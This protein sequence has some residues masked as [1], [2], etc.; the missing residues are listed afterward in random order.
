MRP[1]DPAIAAQLVGAMIN[2]AA[3]L[4]RWAVDADETLASDRYARPLFTGLLNP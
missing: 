3:E 1:V 2:G 4:R